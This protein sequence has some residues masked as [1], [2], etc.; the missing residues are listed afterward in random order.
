MREKKFKKFIEVLKVL[1]TGLD[2]EVGGHQWTLGYSD[3]DT[4]KV[5]MKM[6]RY[7]IDNGVKS[8]E[9]EILL[10][11]P[12]LQDFNNMIDYVNNGVDDKD[13]EKAMLDVALNKALTPKDRG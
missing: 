11:P 9:E 3:D 4:P 6:T 1:D 7:N 2:I 12:I 8:E 5:A 10:E 13:L